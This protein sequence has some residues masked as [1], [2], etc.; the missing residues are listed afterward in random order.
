MAMVFSTSVLQLARAY[1]ALADDGV[2]HSVSLIKRGEDFDSK[3]VFTAKTAKKV[4]EMLEHVIKKD[5][6]AYQARVDGFRVAGKTG[7]VKKSIVGG[8]AK[9]RYLAVFVGM[10]PVSDPKFVIAVM[11]NE[12]SAGKYYGGQ[13]AAPVFSKVMAGALRVYGIATDKEESMPVLLTSVK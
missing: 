13:V 11:V 7:T 8:Y 10:A 3:R 12:P 5:G 6:T 2:L 4:R 1:T 9:D